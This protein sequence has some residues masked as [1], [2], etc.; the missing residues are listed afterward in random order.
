MNITIEAYLKENIDDNI[1][2]KQW[3]E[4]KKIPVFLRNIY[5]FHEME[6]LDNVCI[7]LEINDEAPG[8]DVI[9]KHIKRIEELSS[10]QIVLYYK[11][12]TR[13]RRKSLIK[14]RIPFI[15]EDGQMFLPFL[16]L[17]LKNASQYVEKKATTFSTST[18]RAYLYFLYN[19]DII[20]N[21]MEL[22]IKLG[23]TTMT[24]SRALNELYNAKL[25]FY[26]IGG[27][28]GRSKEYSRV[29]D[30]KYFQKGKSFIKSPI[31]KVVYSRKI[32]E[33]ALVAG[34]EALAELYMINPP[35]YLV[36]AISHIQLNKIGFDIVENKDKV[37]DE[38]LV[39]VQIWDYDPELFSKKN[40]VDL[41]SLYAT[42]KEEND[43]RIE[44]AIEEVLR[45]EEWYTD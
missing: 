42:F 14:N 15:I 43:E 36:R 25:I 26:K 30:P 29:P 39:E 16:G 24:A 18:Q 12:I 27:K 8:V 2:I 22:A 6:I 1:T 10:R 35:G 23:T 28:T 41:M 32:P 45:G 17:D 34:L 44:Q 33:N 4:K 40:H 13:Y 5:E 11:D 3:D 7:L 19:K 21:T 38:K 20:V 9:K 37:K 31:K